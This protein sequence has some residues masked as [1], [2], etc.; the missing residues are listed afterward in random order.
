MINLGRDEDDTAARLKQGVDEVK[1]WLQHNG[2]T[3]NE[4]KEQV[5]GTSVALRRSLLRVGF[6][7][8]SIKSEV[9]DLGGLS[10]KG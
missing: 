1:N 9:L 7:E 2:L 6:N 3:L 8:T 4:A 10:K 5:W